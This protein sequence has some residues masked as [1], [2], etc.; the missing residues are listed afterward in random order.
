M[1]SKLL[2]AL[3]CS[4]FSVSLLSGQC[5]DKS[6]L[7]KRIVYL[8][9]SSKITL[10]AQLEELS[11]YLSVINKCPF[12]ADSTHAL[13]LQRVGALFFLQKDYATGIKYT[14]QSIAIIN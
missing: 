9:D 14:R 1:H 11:P 5:P 8:R 13:L 3:G 6:F 4:L 10:K 2:L 12:K 7:W